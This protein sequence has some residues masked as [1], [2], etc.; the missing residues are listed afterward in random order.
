MLKNIQLALILAIAS[1]G[2]NN[3]PEPEVETWGDAIEV[4]ADA[5]CS[6]AERCFE[7]EFELFFETHENCVNDV[8]IDDCSY[9]NSTGGSCRTPY[10]QDRTDELEQ[11]H[12][13]MTDIVCTATTAPD[14]CFLAFE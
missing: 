3:K 8:V 13:E 11:C 1:C 2:D 4:W 5:W 14:S 6:Y 7:Q 9:R 12:Q 10:P